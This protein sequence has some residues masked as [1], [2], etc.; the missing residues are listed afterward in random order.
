MDNDSVATEELIGETHEAAQL[1]EAQRDGAVHAA[2]TDAVKSAH[3][4]ARPGDTEDLVDDLLA[5]LVTGLSPADAAELENNTGSSSHLK[6]V[7]ARTRLAADDAA[8]LG[9]KANGFW[10]I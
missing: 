5:G 1:E 10:L 7:A 2:F 4:E 9:A 6:I 8:R 3:K